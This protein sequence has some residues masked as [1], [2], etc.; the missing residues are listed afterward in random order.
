MTSVSHLPGNRPNAVEYLLCHWA[1]FRGNI[2]G[3]EYA[4]VREQVWLECGFDLDRQG[5]ELLSLVNR[6]GSTLQ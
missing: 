2:P 3:D 4:L 5:P 6:V 1:M